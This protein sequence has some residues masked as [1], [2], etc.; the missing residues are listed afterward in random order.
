[1]LFAVFWPLAIFGIF[2]FVFGLIG[3]VVAAR[4]LR[5]GEAAG[6][7]FFYARRDQQPIKFKIIGLVQ[8]LFSAYVALQF[9]LNSFVYAL[10]K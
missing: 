6:L 1:M 9:G 7:G 5:R 8:F 2:W 10:N 3:C 4:N